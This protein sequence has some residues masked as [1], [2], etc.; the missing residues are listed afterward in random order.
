MNNLLSIRYIVTCI[1]RSDNASWKPQ[2][3]SACF[4]LEEAKSFVRNAMEEYVDHIT[5]AYGAK[6]CPAV[7]FDAMDVWSDAGIGCSWNI[8]EVEV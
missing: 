7:D 1:D 4:D 3:L 2:V 5:I 6:L 8:S